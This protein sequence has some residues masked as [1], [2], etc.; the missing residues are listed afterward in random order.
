MNRV[1]RADLRCHDLGRYWTGRERAPMG[2]PLTCLSARR[3]PEVGGVRD[4]ED[5]PEDGPEWLALAACLSFGTS[6]SGP[7]RR[8][9]VSSQAERLAPWVCTVAVGFF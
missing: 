9:A 8:G 5:V 1:Y 4:W 3:V 2:A 7:L 6:G